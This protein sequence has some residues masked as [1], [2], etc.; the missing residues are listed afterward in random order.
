ML[1]KSWAVIVSGILMLSTLLIPSVIDAPAAGTQAAATLASAVAPQTA[2]PVAASATVEPKP[3]EEPAVEAV[4]T[5]ETVSLNAAERAS[6]ANELAS[7]VTRHPREL[8]AVVADIAESE[9]LPVSPTLVLSIA[10][11]ETRGKILAVSP[12]GAAG[13]AQATP[14][15]YMLEGFDGK[16]YVT[17]DY[18]MGTR[19]YIMKKPLGDAMAIA[20]PLIERNTPARRVHAKKLL[21]EAI[22]LRREGM[23]ELEALYPVANDVFVRKIAEADA[24]NLATLNELERLIDRGAPR[25]QMKRFHQRVQKDYRYL[26]NVQRRG[27][28]TYAKQLEDRRD[29]LLRK[30]FG[31]TPAKVITT[32]PYEAGEYLGE[33]LDARF[34]PT[35]MTRFLAAHLDTKRRQAIDLGVPP[36]ELEAWTAALYNG[37]AIN[38][39]RMRAGLLRSI[40]ETQQYMVKV[41]YRRAKLDMAMGG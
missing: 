28:A 39:K 24:Y 35:K 19:S 6:L 20:S 34:S 3:A 9:P 38:V 36:D 29:T 26:M 33:A 37:G 32:R 4:K 5:A 7:W 30:R 16:I 12:A 10:W 1:Q 17:T 15:A 41:P 25:A 18:L 14:A 21:A 23:D 40:R 22:E 27:W 31:T 2:P 11:A 13:L 8:V